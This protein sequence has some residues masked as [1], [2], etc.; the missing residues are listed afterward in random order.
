MFQTGNKSSRWTFRETVQE[1]TGSIE[2]SN[3][4]FCYHENLLS[5]CRRK[6][7][8]FLTPS[9]HTL[10]SFLSIQAGEK[11]SSHFPFLNSWFGEKKTPLS[12]FFSIPYC[13]PLGE[14]I[15]SCVYSF[16]FFLYE[17]LALTPTLCGSEYFLHW[18]ENPW[19][20]PKP[21][22]IQASCRIRCL[23]AHEFLSFTF[24]L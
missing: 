19:V 13:F 23:Y 24:V 7:G 21:Y 11:F 8:L 22:E 1:Y 2:S 10:K 17:V 5:M 20:S 18:A 15:S 16:F 12:Y 4:V 14:K 6:T 3:A 9:P